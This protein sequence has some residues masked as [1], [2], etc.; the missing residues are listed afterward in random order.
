MNEIDYEYKSWISE[1]KTRYK[2]AQIKASVAVNGELLKF[3]F[4]LGKDIS[5]KQFAN[6]YGSAFYKTLSSDLITEFP[7]AKGFSPTNLKYSFYFY[8]LYKEEVQR[9]CPI[10]IHAR[11]IEQCRNAR[12]HYMWWFRLS[13]TTLRLLLGQPLFLFKSHPAIF[14]PG[15]INYNLFANRKICPYNI[16]I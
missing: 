12:Y 6:S 4:D 3:Y 5:E 7:D 11:V 13:S 15:P 14:Q 2:Q 8:D 10:S 9:G 16:G 1:L